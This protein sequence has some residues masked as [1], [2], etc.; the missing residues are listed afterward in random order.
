MLAH[1]IFEPSHGAWGFPV[2][3]VKKKDGE[4][5]FVLTTGL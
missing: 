3:L 4:V 5:H 2:V 1:D